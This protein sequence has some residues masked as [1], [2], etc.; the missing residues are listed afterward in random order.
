MRMSSH[1]CGHHGSGGAYRCDG[2]FATATD[3]PDEHPDIGS[4]TTPI[5]MEFVENEEAEGSVDRIPNLPLT[6][7]GKQKF[8]HHIV[9]QENVRGGIEDLLADFRLGLSGVGS[10]S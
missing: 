5:G 4:L 7:P 1:T 8:K 6:M 3:P 10:K 2:G 9:R